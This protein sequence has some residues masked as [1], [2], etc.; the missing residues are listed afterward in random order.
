[1]RAR[2]AFAGRG[3]NVS[4]SVPASA[5]LRSF[6]AVHKIEVGKIP[7]VR[8]VV[9]PVVGPDV[10]APDVD[11][12][13]RIGWNDFTPELSA[14]GRQID[15]EDTRLHASLAKHVDPAFIDGPPD[16]PFA[17]FAPPNPPPR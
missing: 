15:G 4:T 16:R 13:G 11:D 1:M 7:H 9:R 5:S 17:R 10:N 8:I 6:Q 14:P 12:P 2:C 3:T